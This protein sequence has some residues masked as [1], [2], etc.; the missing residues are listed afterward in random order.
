MDILQYEL[1]R[2][3][4]WTADLQK[5]TKSFENMKA[6]KTAGDLEKEKVILFLGF[7]TLMELSAC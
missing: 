2:H 7:K 6:S 1:T 3:G 4:Q 5:K